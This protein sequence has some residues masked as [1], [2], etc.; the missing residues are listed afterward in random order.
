[1]WVTIQY[2]AIPDF[3]FVLSYEL[4][5]ATLDPTWMSEWV[6]ACWSWHISEDS[7]V[8]TVYL[9]FCCFS[10]ELLFFSKGSM[11]CWYN[12]L[13]RMSMKF[14]CW[15]KPSLPEGVFLHYSIV[16]H[17]L[18]WLRDLPLHH[19]W[20]ILS[21]IS[22]LLPLF[23]YFK[24]KSGIKTLCENPHCWANWWNMLEVKWSP[25]SDQTMSG[26][27]EPQNDWHRALDQLWGGSVMI[28]ID[29]CWPVCKTIHVIFFS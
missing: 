9:L 10:F 28:H 7:E 15:E 29:D 23:H 2:I 1:M 27:A 8:A 5:I 19:V 11:I 17:N 16:Q 3:H 13:D 24:S 6:C 25:P 18:S 12:I 4:W 26:I 20:M 22:L 14:L 21:W